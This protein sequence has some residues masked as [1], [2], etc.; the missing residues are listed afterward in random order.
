MK[1]GPRRSSASLSHTS[2]S[3]MRH[4]PWKGADSAESFC[5]AITPPP[6]QIGRSASAGARDC[7]RLRREGESGLGAADE[8]GLAKSRDRLDPPER[9]FDPF[10]DALAL[11]VASVSGGA[12]VDGGEACLACH[13]RPH[14]HRAQL[15]DEIGRIVALVGAERDRARTIR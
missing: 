8:A 3:A 9:L 11:A 14:V 12:P 7:R 15:F 1:A 4:L 2:I 13:V 6:K 10:T 5:F